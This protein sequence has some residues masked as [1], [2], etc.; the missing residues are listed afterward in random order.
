MQ[1]ML[2]LYSQEAG[3]ARLSHAEQ[4][5]WMGAYAAFTDALTAADALRGSSHLASSTIATTVQVQEG[6]TQVLDGPYADTR[7]QLAGYFLIEADDLDAALQWAERCPGARHG[8][9][10][11]RP[12]GQPPAP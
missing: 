10:E 4:K 5:E 9:V 3:W 6:K 7:E 2:L 11:I 1:Y 12:L 8:F